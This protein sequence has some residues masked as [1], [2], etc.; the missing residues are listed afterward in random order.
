M[1]AKAPA[2]RVARQKAYAASIGEGLD[3]GVRQG[4]AEG[5]EDGEAGGD[6]DATAGVKDR[7][8]AIEAEE[9]A[10]AE[11]AVAVATPPTA[12]LEYVDEL[13][14]G[15]PGYVLPLEQRTLACV[16]YDAATGQCV[17]D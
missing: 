3:A 5:R 11:A 17:G 9:A 7:L 13:P 12:G 1:A 4:K 2:Q 10:A 6:E 15:E 14:S 8:A 16:G